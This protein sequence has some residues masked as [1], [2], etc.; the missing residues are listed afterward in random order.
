MIILNSCNSTHTDH[1]RPSE[2]N[3]ETINSM[4]KSAPTERHEAGFIAVGD[5]L[6]L[7]GGRG[8]MPVD[9]FDIESKR[10]TQGAESPIELHHFQPVVYQHYI[11]ILGAMAG[12]YPDEQP[13]EHI[14]IYDTKE[15]KWIRGADIPIARQRGSTG[16]IISG[17]QIYMIGGIK[18]GHRGDHKKWVDKFDISNNQW[19]ILEDA[20]RARDHFQAVMHA[21]KIYAIAGRTTEADPNPFKNTIA[22]VD[23]YDIKKTLGLQ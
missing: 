16:V 3:W 21:N 17:D 9:I 7:L 11:F 6:Y 4:D 10:W 8:I 18:N 22:E 23:I 2:T 19:T 5:K 13:I 12:P 20:P 1:Q 14:V 15:D